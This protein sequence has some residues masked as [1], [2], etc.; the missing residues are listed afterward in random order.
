[1]K[2]F[3]AILVLVTFSACLPF[4]QPVNGTASAVVDCASSA[5][6]NIAIGHLTDVDGS[7]IATDWQSALEAD[8]LRLG[9][10]VL[11]C[12]LQYV[13]SRTQTAR[14]SNGAEIND[15]TKETRANE[16][17]R[18]HNVVFKK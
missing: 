8:A 17:L 11:A 3:F 16:W 9:P 12:I 10:D 1:M 2:N 5:I 18:S 15:V 13:I 7:L 14:A 4:K 6:T